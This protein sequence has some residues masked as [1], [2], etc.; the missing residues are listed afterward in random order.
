MFIVI[1]IIYFIKTTILITKGLFH[2]NNFISI[3]FNIYHLYF[4]LPT[5]VEDEMWYFDDTLVDYFSDC[6]LFE[7]EYNLKRAFFF[8]ILYYCLKFI[9]YYLNNCG[10]F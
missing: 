9:I 1:L 7:V 6:T 4:G 10:W 2:T 5:I 8:R 3:F